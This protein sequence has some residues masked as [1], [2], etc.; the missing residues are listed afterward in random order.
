MN[1]YKDIKKYNL[2]DNISWQAGLF[3]LIQNEIWRADGKDKHNSFFQ[4]LGIKPLPLLSIQA[5]SCPNPLPSILFFPSQ[6]ERS[7]HG[8]PVIPRARCC[9]TEASWPG[10]S[11]TTEYG[12]KEHKIWGSLGSWLTQGRETSKESFLGV[13]GGHSNLKT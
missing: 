9:G 13:C 2:K 11:R 12:T 4:P 8:Y 1:K 7:F 10:L 3:Y 6:A 5:S